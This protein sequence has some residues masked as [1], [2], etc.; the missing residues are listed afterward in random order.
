M[1]PGPLGLLWW[2]SRKPVWSVYEL[3]GGEAWLRAR[4]RRKLIRSFLWPVGALI[5]AVTFYP[6]SLKWVPYLQTLT[7]PFAQT[8]DS[9]HLWIRGLWERLM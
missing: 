9:A 5:V 8:I 3:V 6:D 4:H 1:F 7:Q 2:W